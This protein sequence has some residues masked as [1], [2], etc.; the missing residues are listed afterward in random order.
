MAH[1]RDYIPRREVELVPWAENFTLWA[2]NY[3]DD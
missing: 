3:S 1:S 2:G